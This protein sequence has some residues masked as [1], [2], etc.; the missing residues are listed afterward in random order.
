MRPCPRL[1]A[2][3]IM[4]G[5]TCLRVGEPLGRLATDLPPGARSKAAA[6]SSRSP[7]VKPRRRR[8]RGG[9]RRRRLGEGLELDGGPQADWPASR[10]AQRS[11]EGIFLPLS[12]RL[13]RGLWDAGARAREDGDAVGQAGLAEGVA[14]ESH[15]G[16]SI[17]VLFFAALKSEER[18]PTGAALPT[19]QLFYVVK[20]VLLRPGRLRRQPDIAFAMVAGLCRALLAGSHW[21]FTSGRKLKRYDRFAA[22][23]RRK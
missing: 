3:T 16:F 20:A 15:N 18:S 22:G 14:V 21:L 19:T 4:A 5:S 9:R 1:N 10:R 17:G 7:G 6:C 13:T 8:S 2:L 23:F 11:S 12:M